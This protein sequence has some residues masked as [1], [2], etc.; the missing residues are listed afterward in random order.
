MFDP[1]HATARLFQKGGT[2]PSDFLGTC[3]AFGNARSYLTATHCIGTL[4]PDKLVVVRHDGT[5][6]NARNLV[7]HETADVSIIEIDNV[8]LENVNVFSA[9]VGNYSLGEDFF[10]YGYPEIGIEEAPVARSFSGT[11]QRF[12]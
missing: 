7:V 8:H 2:E 4:D 11:F 9:A 3:F 1:R 5:I 6:C 10:A 12:Y